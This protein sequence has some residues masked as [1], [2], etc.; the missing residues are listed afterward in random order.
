M[1]LPKQQRNEIINGLLPLLSEVIE[2]TQRVTKRM[3]ATVLQNGV[4]HDLKGQP[5][6]PHIL[7]AFM[8]SVPVKVNHRRRLLEVIDKAPTVKG[9]EEDL[10]RYLI[11]F[12]K[13]KEAITE[14]ISKLK[15]E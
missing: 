14:S 12:G 15:N 4:T 13:S 7:Y 9:M 5:I 6:N 10:A 2:H 8:D 3:G 1:I 11:K